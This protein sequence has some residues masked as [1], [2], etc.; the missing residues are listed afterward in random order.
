MQFVAQKLSYRL[1]LCV[2]ITINIITRE[3]KSSRKS[4]G[5]GKMKSG[6]LLFHIV[7]HQT[8]KQ[9]NIVVG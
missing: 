6:Q 1:C 4:H 5:W 3:Q 9:T 7:P 8:N 2:E